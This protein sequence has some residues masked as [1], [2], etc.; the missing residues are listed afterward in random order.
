MNNAKNLNKKKALGVTAAVLALAVGATASFALFTD[1]A[2]IRGATEAGKLAIGITADKMTADGDFSEQLLNTAFEENVQNFNPGDFREIAYRIDN[3]Q[4]KAVRT[5]DTITVK[6]TPDTA[7]MTDSTKTVDDLFAEFDPEGGAIHLVQG[8]AAGADAVV[9]ASDGS[10]SDVSFAKGGLALKDKYVKD[11]AI[12]LVYQGSEVNLSGTGTNAEKLAADAGTTWVSEETNTVDRAYTLYFEKDA[13]NQWQGAK[14][15]ISVDVSA[16]QYAN[17][18]AG[19]ATLNIDTGA[20]TVATN[21]GV[22]TVEMARELVK[23]DD[24]GKVVS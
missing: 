21:A 22:N 3:D 6:V 19:D 8:T 4:N 14:V 15:D 17:T 7:M 10:T 2:A 16:V 9:I 24:A 23:T 1:T 18:A 20:H 13:L 11:G 5:N 12:Y